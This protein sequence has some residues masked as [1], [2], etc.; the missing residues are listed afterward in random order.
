MCKKEMTNK[1]KEAGLGYKYTCIYSCIYNAVYMYTHTHVYTY[2]K[3]CIIS[4]I[5]YT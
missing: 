1:A 3:L 2:I 5:Y 4:K